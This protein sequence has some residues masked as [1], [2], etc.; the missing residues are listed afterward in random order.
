VSWAICQSRTPRPAGTA[1]SNSFPRGDTLI[2][3]LAFAFALRGR[4]TAAAV[5][6]SGIA[7][8]IILVACSVATAGQPAPTPAMEFGL[9]EIGAYA[10]FRILDFASPAL[11]TRK[12]ADNSGL[13]GISRNGD[14]FL[15]S[16]KTKSGRHPFLDDEV[17]IADLSGSAITRIRPA[18]R[19]MQAYFAEL[20]PDSSAIAFVGNFAR[21]GEHAAYGLHLL[22]VNGE[23]RT[24]VPTSESKTPRAVAWSHDGREIVYDTADHVFLYTLSAGTTAMLTAGSSPTWSPDGAWI[25]YRLPNGAAGLIRPDA[26]RTEVFLSGVRLVRGVRWSPDGRYVLFTDERTGEIRIHELKNGRSTT[27]LSPTDGYD[28]SRLRW[29]RVHTK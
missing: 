21:T 15:L 24:L 23:I 13:I 9:V 2:R 4:R 16:T 8:A 29:V 28:D 12:L 25:S 5:P 10:Q 17:D 20:S 19:G 22:K 6:T 26:S 11:T 7:A 1:P 14:L 3:S 18:I 27:V